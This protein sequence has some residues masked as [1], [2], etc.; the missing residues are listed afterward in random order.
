MRASPTPTPTL[1]LGDVRSWWF[2]DRLLTVIGVSEG[3]AR[4]DMMLHRIRPHAERLDG[5]AARATECWPALANLLR[6][7]WR[8]PSCQITGDQRGPCRG[9]DAYPQRSASAATGAGATENRSTGSAN[10]FSS[11]LPRSVKRMSAPATKSFT[12]RVTRHSPG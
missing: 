1:S 6:R 9:N 3:T 7:V 10:P 8:R 12:V 2:P 11:R 5:H 4:D